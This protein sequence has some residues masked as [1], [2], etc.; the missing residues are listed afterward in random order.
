[1]LLLQDKSFFQWSKEF[2]PELLKQELFY[3]T[4]IFGEQSVMK[5][6]D[7]TVMYPVAVAIRGDKDETF[8]EH[9]EG[10]A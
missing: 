9:V 8:D 6:M 5:A 1:M 3:C 7:L 2:I 4:Q 10:E